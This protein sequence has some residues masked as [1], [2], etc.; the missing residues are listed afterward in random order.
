M[1][2][3]TQRPRSFGL[4]ARLDRRK[5]ISGLDRA[6]TAVLLAAPLAATVAAVALT[7][8]RPG[9]FSWR[10]MAILG[11]FYVPAALGVTIGYHR[12]LAHRGFEAHPVVRGVLLVFGAWSIQGGPL[13]WAAVHLKHHSFSD[14]ELDPHSPAAKSLFHAHMGWLFSAERPEPEAFARAQM[15]D[16]VARFVGRTAFWWAVLGLA[17]PFVFGGWSGFLWGGLVRVFLVHHVTWSVN[18]VCHRF[19]SRP[20]RTG[21]DR[22]TN[23]LLVGLIALGEGWHNNHHAFPRS[24]FH[25]L[26]WKEIDVSG[27]AIRLMGILRLASNIYRVPGDVVA[28]RRG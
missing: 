4:L 18:S 21:A 15:A 3:M 24:A 20:F 17:L 14:K 8:L 6:A 13:S 26:R 22:S 12:M 11:G 5:P 16:P 2:I 27:Y 1:C 19:G 25:G 7:F 28:A 10:D 23:N 9:F